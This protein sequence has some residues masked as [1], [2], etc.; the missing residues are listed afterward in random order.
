MDVEF[1]AEG[2]DPVVVGVRL[3]TVG[4]SVDLVI[5]SFAPH[6][7]WNPQTIEYASVS[8]GTTGSYTSPSVEQVQQEIENAQMWA[9]IEFEKS[10]AKALVKFGLLDADPTTIPVQTL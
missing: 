10:V 6:S 2:F 8:V 1:T 4:E 7:V 3:P 5:Q 9:K